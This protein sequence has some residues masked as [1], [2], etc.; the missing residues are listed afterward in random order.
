[1]STMGN[2]WRN[3]TNWLNMMS[4]A[5]PET[6]KEAI[7]NAVE[8]RK[9]YQDNKDT[10]DIT[11]TVANKISKLAMSGSQINIH[12]GKGGENERSIYVKNILDDYFA[13]FS[14]SVTQTNAFGGIVSKIYTTNTGELAIDTL[15]QDRII[16]LATNGNKITSAIIVAEEIILPNKVI[17]ERQ[18]LHKLVGDTLTITQIILEDGRKVPLEKYEQWRN[19]TEVIEINNIDTI[20]ASMMTCPV[21][22]R[23]FGRE[24]MYGEPIT[25]G[26]EK[27][28]AEVNMFNKKLTKEINLK[29]SFVGVSD[30]LFD[31]SYDSNGNAREKT[32]PKSGLYQKFKSDDADFFEEF[33]PAIR[34]QSYINSI[35][36][37]LAQIEKVIGVSRGILTETESSNATATEIKRSNYDTMAIVSE[38]R[39]RVETLFNE[40]LKQIDAVSDSNG[41]L[42][43][44]VVISFEWSGDL[45]EDSQEQF[46]QIQWGYASG[47]IH[48]YEAR[49]FITDESHEE[50]K[51]SMPTGSELIENED[52][53][54]QMVI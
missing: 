7:N 16:I 53:T 14:N 18:E 24:A 46:T 22:T 51:E 38:I 8:N 5:P 45:L 47:L 1:M 34:E 13:K 17:L 28:I 49:A 41:N 26:A 44:D 27:L 35:N 20:L 52:P 23:K 29:D 15:P 39:K 19:L 36:F 48:D 37:K 40:L 32:T 12:D 30:L 9:K 4:Q 42:T 43:N 21:D 3:I 11:Y 50:A 2:L 10:L 33:T 25:F 31:T 54:Q 6:T